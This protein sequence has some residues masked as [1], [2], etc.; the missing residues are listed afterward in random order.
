MP[1]PTKIFSEDE[2]WKKCTILF[3]WYYYLIDNNFDSYYYLIDNNYVLYT[4]III[5]NNKKN[6]IIN[7]EHSEKIRF[8]MRKLNTYKDPLS[9]FLY[10]IKEWIDF[11]PEYQRWLV[12]IL[13]TNKN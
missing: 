10:K 2:L 5:T 3:D 8:L 12:G 13:K 9:I 7:D 6:I 4:K 1:K 11:N